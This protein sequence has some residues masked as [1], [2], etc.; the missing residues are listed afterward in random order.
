MIEL[1]LALIHHPVFN[2][3]KSIVATTI[4]HFDIHDIAR[5]CRSYGVKN[6]HLVHPSK[7]QLMFV[8]RLK[9]H[10]LS[11][12]GKEFN[13]LRAEAIKII[14]TSESLKALKEQF[15]FDQIFATS[16]KNH[17]DYPMI[18]FDDLKMKLEKNKKNDELKKILLLFGTGSGLTNTVFQ[19][20]DGLLEP[21]V[22]YEGSDFRHLSVRAAVAI[23][24]DRLHRS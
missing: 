17:Q 15:G 6:Y 7:E 14:K 21:I 11:G 8:E 18:S 24:L 12:S 3:N 10:W 13:P 5:V 2:R 1:H 22:G 16:A 9:D 19:L 23:V 20:C 4:T